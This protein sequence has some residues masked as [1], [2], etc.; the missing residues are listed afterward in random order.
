M[1]SSQ[2]DQLLSQGVLDHLGPIVVNRV[3]PELP[4][5]RDTARAGRRLMGWLGQRDNEG[6]AELRDLVGELPDKVSKRALEVA[7]GN[8]GLLLINVLETLEI[9]VEP[10]YQPYLDQFPL[11]E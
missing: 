9:D 6:V 7:Q 4:P 2:L 5:V 3:H 11:P 8:P 10:E 1:V